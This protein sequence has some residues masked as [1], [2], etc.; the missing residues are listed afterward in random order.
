VLTIVP[1]IEVAAKE[2]AEK[3]KR[4]EIKLKM[5]TINS[6]P[7]NKSFDNWVIKNP[8]CGLMQHSRLAVVAYLQ[9]TIQHKIKFTI[10]HLLNKLYTIKKQ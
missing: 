10:R 6:E 5:P 4:P 1:S 9:H 7:V 8:A 3:T 2:A